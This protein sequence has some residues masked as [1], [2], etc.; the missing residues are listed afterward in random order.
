MNTY[1][2]TTNDDP[3]IP[4]IV[5][6]DPT[7]MGRT[8]DLK[9]DV[10]RLDRLESAC[11]SAMTASWTDEETLIGGHMLSSRTYHN[12]GPQLSIATTIDDSLHMR[13]YELSLPAWDGRR[14]RDAA[15]FTILRERGMTAPMERIDDA[16][17]PTAAA[18]LA[19]AVRALSTG[20]SPTKQEVLDASHVLCAQILRTHHDGPIATRWP[21]AHGATFDHAP[22]T[23]FEPAEMV[24]NRLD[25]HV[26]MPVPAFPSVMILRRMDGVLRFDPVF[27]PC[28]LRDDPDPMS[29][30]RSVAM[31]HD[32]MTG[33]KP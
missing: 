13:V 24:W 10:L 30:M 6:R 20:S 8:R 26:T 11:R 17:L 7:A 3:R 23:P 22:A 29:A 32:V 33:G 18:L 12:E 15:I 27:S 14:R 31:V 5:V 28:L 21:K 1:D 9:N 25:R 2:T 19:A 4:A 16:T